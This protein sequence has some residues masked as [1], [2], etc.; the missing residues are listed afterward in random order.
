M[1]SKFYELV[2][3]AKDLLKE[4]KTVPGSYNQTYTKRTQQALDMI[5]EAL[6]MV[7]VTEE[8]EQNS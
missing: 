2:V 7:E 1:N 5:V 8:N 6:S 4:N 3:R